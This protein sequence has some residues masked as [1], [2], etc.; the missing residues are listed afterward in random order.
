MYYVEFSETNKRQV[1]ADSLKIVNDP[2]VKFAYVQLFKLGELVF[3]APLD[4]IICIS[5]Q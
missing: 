3:F 1:D 5:K 2:G 4:T